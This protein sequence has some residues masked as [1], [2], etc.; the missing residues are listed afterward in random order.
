[1]LFDEWALCNVQCLGAI[2]TL[3]TLSLE[4]DSVASLEC[5]ALYELGPH[6]RVLR[7]MGS[8]ASLSFAEI[9]DWRD[10]LFTL[11]EYLCSL[12]CFETTQDARALVHAASLQSQQE[13]QT[14]ACNGL[15]IWKFWHLYVVLDRHSSAL[16]GVLRCRNNVGLLHKMSVN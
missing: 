11:F 16:R 8:A 1:L 13:E 15:I 4:A 6:I 10:F 3:H 2:E 14:K 5:H 12:K 7:L 9:P